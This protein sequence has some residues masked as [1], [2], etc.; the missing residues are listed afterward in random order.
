MDASAVG[1]ASPAEGG[2]DLPGDPAGGEL[3]PRSGVE[4]HAEEIPPAPGDTPPEPTDRQKFYGLKFN[5]LDRDLTPDER[6][7]WNSIY[8]SYRGRSALTGT[9]IGIDP[10]SVRVRNPETGEMEKQTMYCAIVVPYRVRIVIPATVCD[11]EHGRLLHRLYHHQ[12][13]P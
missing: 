11:A 4:P 2:G 5:R 12:G 3:P 8:A 7:E 9:I 1:A 10:Y 6:Q 13:G